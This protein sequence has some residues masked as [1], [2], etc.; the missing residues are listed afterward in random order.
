MAARRDGRRTS[1]CCARQ[2]CEFGFYRAAHGIG[3]QA[4]VVHVQR[5]YACRH[6]FA[7]G[8]EIHLIC[9]AGEIS[10]YEFPLLLQFRH[11]GGDATGFDPRDGITICVRVESFH[12]LPFAAKDH[13]LQ[14]AFSF[15]G[16]QKK[17]RN[18]FGLDVE[19]ETD[20]LL[21]S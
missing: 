2:I 11:L 19:V 15:E 21:A 5:I 12:I 7:H 6:G 10:D 13:P 14:H 16:L 4:G 9:V 3:C 1:R 17:G 18:A 8:G 20:S